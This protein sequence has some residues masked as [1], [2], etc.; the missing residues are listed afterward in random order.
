MEALYSESSSQLCARTMK[1]EFR[2]AMGLERVTIVPPFHP[3]A[4]RDQI[5]AN[6]CAGSD[7]DR[8]RRSRTIC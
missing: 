1:I 7:D 4:H 2:L 6:G 5:A 8:P 3:T